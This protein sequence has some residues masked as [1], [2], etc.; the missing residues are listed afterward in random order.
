MM[1]VLSELGGGQLSGIRTLD[2]V[3][4]VERVGSWNDLSASLQVGTELL[5]VQSELAPPMA[6]SGPNFVFGSLLA[7]YSITVSIDQKSPPIN[8]NSGSLLVGRIAGVTAEVFSD[9]ALAWGEELDLFEIGGEQFF[10]ARDVEDLLRLTQ[11]WRRDWRCQTTMLV[12][13]NG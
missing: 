2:L 12:Q 6:S 8:E 11:A 1:R 7:G 3:S 5:I 13:R 9:A 4:G 10:A